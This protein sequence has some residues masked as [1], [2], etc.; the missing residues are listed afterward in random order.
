VSEAVATSLMQELIAYALTDQ[1]RQRVA[2][3]GG[4]GGRRALVVGGAGRMG[5]WFVGFLASQGFAVEV[6]D[7]AGPV[8]G[9]AH[10]S[11]W[12]DSDLTHDLVVLAT[13]LRVTA[14][15]LDSLADRRPPGVVFDIGSLKGPLAAGLAR[16]AEAGV[17]VTSLH[18]MFGPDTELLSGR[19]VILVDAGVAAAN[20]V[21]RSLFTSTMAELVEMSVEDHDRCIA[22]VLGLSHALN[23][24]FSSALAD[25]G[26]AA[27]RL[28]QLSSTTFER[29]LEVAQAVAQENPHLY[30]EIQRLN[31]FGGDSLAALRAAVGRLQEAVARGDEP[32]FVTMMRGG[33]T[34]LG[35]LRP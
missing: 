8:A 13:E 16:L 27:T 28:A 19:H 12:R 2:A 15:I 33:R 32:G 6:A 10:L 25:S 5:R 14:G 9:H 35:E 21:A 3:H 29:Q 17:R 7:P 20:R 26:E 4:G 23:I 1:E 34:Y 18:P 31:E 24:A 22:Y 30:F 11:D